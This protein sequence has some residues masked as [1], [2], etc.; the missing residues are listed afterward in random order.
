MVGSSATLNTGS[1]FKGTIMA[2]VSIS[3]SSGVR[4]RG[5]LLAGSGAV[6][7]IDDRINR[8]RLVKD[9]R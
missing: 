9:T 5:R 4:V 1:K 3:V 2:A 8:Y 6:T 7:L